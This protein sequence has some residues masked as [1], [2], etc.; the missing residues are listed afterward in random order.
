MAKN[1]GCINKECSS[2]KKKTLFDNKNNF[3]PICGEQLYYV[4][5]KC[6][7]QLEENT[8]LCLRHLE[9]KEQNIAKAKETGAGIVA[10]AGVV[11]VG[12]RKYGKEIIKV[13]GKVIKK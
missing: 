4:C 5:K 13:A 12:I 3:C 11:A 1:K 7:T 8:K 9:E 2:C 6:H 10:G